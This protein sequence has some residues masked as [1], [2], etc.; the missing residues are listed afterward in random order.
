MINMNKQQII[1]LGFLG[2]LIIG[3]VFFV[4]GQI[5]K[6]VPTNNFNKRSWLESNYQTSI[7]REL[8]TSTAT[9]TK[10]Y[11]GWQKNPKDFYLPI[12]M[13]HHLDL[14]RPQDPYFVS[15]EI[16]TAQMQW[17]K[18][19]HYQV[20]SYDQFY[21]FLEG[22]SYLPPRA[23]VIT[24][25]DGDTDQYKNAV[26]ILEKFHYPATFFIITKMIGEIDHIDFKMMKTMIKAGMT[27]G[28]HTVSH[29]N[30][31]RLSADQLKAEL[32]NSKKLLEK[33]LGRKI[34]YF[35]YPGG[36]H[37]TS[38]AEAVK[39]AGYLSAVTT[40]HGTLH[41]LNSDSEETIYTL[42]RIHIDDDL[43]SFIHYVTRPELFHNQRR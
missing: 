5:Y 40:I 2:H 19:N 43:S 7:N 10:A 13:Y 27:I 12:L 37:N 21:S 30:V 1:I 33:A 31:T 25:D 39:A 17:L 26:P 20:I 29:P 32:S 16:F 34:N 22:K 11:K 18:D 4:V 42:K 6:S 36:A 35:A 28:S 38:T 3:A 23:V 14:F 24:F 8:A 9:S 15:P 41:N